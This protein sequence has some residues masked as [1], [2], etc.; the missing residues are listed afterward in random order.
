MCV[1]GYQIAVGMLMLGLTQVQIR[2][3]VNFEFVYQDVII[4]PH[5]QRTPIGNVQA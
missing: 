2:I 3:W 4:T 1:H 5:V